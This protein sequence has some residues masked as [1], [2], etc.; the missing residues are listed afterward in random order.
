MSLNVLDEIDQGHSETFLLLQLK[1]SDNF[2]SD[3]C[4]SIHSGILPLL[5]IL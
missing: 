1:R 4:I 2:E 5:I 3:D